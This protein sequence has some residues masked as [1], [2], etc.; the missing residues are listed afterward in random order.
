[1]FGLL[2]GEMWLGVC[3]AVVVDLSPA[4]LTTSCVA[5]YFLIIQIIGGNMNLLVT[6]LT[7]CFNLRVALLI[8]F[9]GCY[10]IGALGFAGTILV[11]TVRNA[12]TSTVVL[13]EGET[14]T[15]LKQPLNSIPAHSN[16][17][18]AKTRDPEVA[19]NDVITR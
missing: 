16:E 8:M 3:T 9:P 18:E 14:S 2:I 4:H 5:L 7:E 11:H 6:P 10:V 19:E 15:Q 13:D 12:H 17:W 1:M